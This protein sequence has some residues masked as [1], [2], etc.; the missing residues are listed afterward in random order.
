MTPNEGTRPRPSPQHTSVHGRV[1]GKITLGEMADRKK[2]SIKRKIK[3]K[4]TAKKTRE[5]IRKAAADAVDKATMGP[6]RRKLDRLRKHGYT[7]RTDVA[8]AALPQTETYCHRYVGR[9]LSWLER[10]GTIP[11]G[12]T[13]RKGNRKRGE[14]YCPSCHVE[15]KLEHGKIPAH[16]P[17]PPTCTHCASCNAY[18]PHVYRGVKNA[19]KLRRLGGCY[20]QIL[21]P[22]CYRD[23]E[24]GAGTTMADDV[25]G[26]SPASDRAINE[27]VSW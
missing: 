21:C 9:S 5:K 2:R 20:N 17:G 10:H 8:D 6:T 1:G 3:N 23:I 11:E 24:S 16:Q 27:G 15:V 25:D 4:L 18:I 13:N 19:A 22:A 7:S 26:S 14:A 12:P